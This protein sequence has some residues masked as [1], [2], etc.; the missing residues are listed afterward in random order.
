M[1]ERQVK[2]WLSRKRYGSNAAAAR[3]GSRVLPP[4][5]MEVEVAAPAPQARRGRGRG[6]GRG[7]A[8]RG[9]R[10][11]NQ[12]RGSKR[13]RQPHSA[14]SSDCEEEDARATRAPRAANMAAAYATLRSGQGDAGLHGM[15]I[16]DELD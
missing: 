1:S 12:Q 15:D 14:G 2:S 9:A 16:V 7:G 8:V 4:K 3:K 11:T 5:L 6:R 13:Q 10:Q